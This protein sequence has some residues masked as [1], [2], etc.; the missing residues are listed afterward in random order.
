MDAR[1]AFEDCDVY[2]SE[3]FMVAPGMCKV[4]PSAALALTSAHQLS[5]DNVE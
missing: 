2:V 3:L 1:Y 5:I 4:G